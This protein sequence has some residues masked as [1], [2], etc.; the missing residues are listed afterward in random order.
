MQASKQ[1]PWGVGSSDKKKCRRRLG[2]KFS[3]R[4]EIRDETPPGRLR[5][6]RAPP[7]VMVGSLGSVIR[8]LLTRH[9][10]CT[11]SWSKTKQVPNHTSRASFRRD[12]AQGMCSCF[13]LPGPLLLLSCGFCFPTGQLGTNSRLQRCIIIQ[14]RGISV[15]GH[16][17]RRRRR[18]TA[19]GGAGQD[20]KAQGSGSLLLFI[21]MAVVV[22]FC[23][24]D[25]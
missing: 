14:A 24:C 7:H 25:C 9:L 18:V 19:S 15:G 16:H 4:T 10:Y 21:I 3:L 2:Q 20:G 17:R 8:P 11:R 23:C 5:R 13:P 22:L 1:S 6:N 12:T